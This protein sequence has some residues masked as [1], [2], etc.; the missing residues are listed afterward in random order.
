MSHLNDGVLRR[1]QD[2]PA[3]TTAA[4]NQHFESCDHCRGRFD[5]I[6]AEAAG[7]SSLL[8][9]PEG[10]IEPEVALLRM[11]RLAAAEPTSGPGAWAWLA[12]LRQFRAFRP[13]AAGLVTVGLMVA[14]VA[15]GVAEGVVQTFQPKSFVAVS[16]DPGSLSAL[17]DLSQFGTYKLGQKPTLHS[18]TTADEAVTGT[19]LGHLL[20]PT[21]P[22]PAS[23]KGAPQYEAFTQVQG[24]F[25][26]SADK[27]RNYAASKG[28]QLPTMPSGIDGTTV[29]VTVGPGVLTVYGAPGLAPASGAAG[30]GSATTSRDR[31]SIPTLAIVQ[32]TTPSVVSDGAS[33]QVLESYLSSLPGVPAD[34]AAQIQAIGDPTSTLPLPL[35]TGQGSHHVDV[36]GHGDGLFVG[37]S[38][39]LGAGVIWEKDG[40][41]YAVVGTLDENGVVSIARSLR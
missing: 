27:A 17:P 2:E 15:T 4:D 39:G 23:V 13:V 10:K 38:T 1:M 36:M 9:V 34:L 21:G 18:A 40:V 7:V 20:A 29:S 26:F 3:T 28:K 37:D 11:R 19:G 14:L 24:S 12:R 32:M 35:P 22:L 8:A 5:E 31:L 30:E 33:V 6:R 16:V 25:T 41:L